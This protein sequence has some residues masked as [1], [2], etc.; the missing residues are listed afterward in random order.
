MEH[1]ET[2]SKAQWTGS[3]INDLPDN[4][5]AYIESGGEKKD[6]KTEPRSLRH[7]PYKDASGKVDLSHVRNLLARLNQIKG[8]PADEET[9][10]RAR[11]EKL[12]GEKTEKSSGGSHIIK[13]NE[14]KHIIYSVIMDS[15]VNGNGT[16]YQ[17]DIQNDVIPPAEIEKAAHAFL[18]TKREIRNTHGGNPSE[19]SYPVESW[20]VPYESVV[21]YQKAMLGE[22]HRVLCTPFGSDILHSGAWVMGIHLNDTDWQDYKD[23]KITAV[24][25]GGTGVRKAATDKDFPVV[26]FVN[27][28]F[29]N[30][31][32]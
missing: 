27:V 21:E 22:D 15:Y 17:P 31:G 26:E 24:S 16:S 5:F 9:K 23:G 13:S 19:G 18:Q 11:M 8:L 30:E 14:S 28:S 32:V 7:G 6:G 20:L 10:I 25:P 3:Y 2:V 4:S 12:L 1:I 29:G